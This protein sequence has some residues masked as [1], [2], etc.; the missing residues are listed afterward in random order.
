MSIISLLLL[1]VFWYV[2]A[3]RWAPM[4]SLTMAMPQTMRNVVSQALVDKV[5]FEAKD[6]PAARR[7]TELNPASED[8]WMMYCATG[9]RDR[10]DIRGTLR[11]CSRAESMNVIS[12]YP[13]FH[14]Q[15]IAEAYEEAGRSCDGLPILR[16]TMGEEKV[17]NITAVFDVGRL[18]ATC[19]QMNDAEEHLRAVVRL[20]VE[21]L[22]SNNW[23]DRPPDSDGP[24]DTYEKA[25]RLYLS[26][27]RQNL[28][29]LL[30]LR[31]E[32]AAALQVCRAAL[33]PWLSHCRCKFE[34][35]NGVA[36]STS[37]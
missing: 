16:K 15:V 30:T 28:S 10:S 20:R 31:H 36:C 9:A 35:R 11:A 13:K 25:S 12:A 24:P 27:A 21:D 26:Q 32:D 1:L 19:G 29:S 2:A 37:S 22:R 3:V 4:D 8:A 17:N 18:E 23:E 33:G 7:A 5:H 6:F 14:A 34:P